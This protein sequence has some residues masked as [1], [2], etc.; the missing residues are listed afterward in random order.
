MSP[1]RWEDVKGM[2]KDKFTVLAERQDPM[3]HG[4][5]GTL[6]VLEFATPAGR[7]RLEWSD[8]PLKLETRAFA[9]K[10]IGSDVTVVHQYD[11]HERVHHFAA[12]RWDAPGSRWVEMRG[13]A[14][15]TLA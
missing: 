2:V 7:M 13:D 11:E 3:P 9:S 14:L 12:Y 8:E 6:E 1:E 15:D 10:R 4:G 5:P